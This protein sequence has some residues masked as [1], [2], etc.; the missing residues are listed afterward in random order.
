MN[1]LGLPLLN[2][3]YVDM[4]DKGLGL[5]GEMKVKRT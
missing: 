2:W 4:G 5:T 3:L 1:L